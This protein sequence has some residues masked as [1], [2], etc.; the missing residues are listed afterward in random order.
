MTKDNRIPSSAVL[1]LYDVPMWESIVHRKMELQCCSDC[2]EYLYPPAPVCSHCLSSALQWKPISGRGKIM[3][4]VRF[5]RAYLDEYPAPYKV[6]AVRLAEGPVLI[7]NPDPIDE[8]SCS[9]GTEVAITYAEMPDGSVL[10][11][12][13]LE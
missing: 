5:E 4:W 12:F 2:G 10:P 7:S 8:S 3:S 1:G 9:I 11:R 6:I 13:R